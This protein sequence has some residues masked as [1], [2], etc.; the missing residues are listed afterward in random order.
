MMATPMSRLLEDVSR[1]HFPLSARHARGD[2]SVRAA[3]G[4]DPDLRVFY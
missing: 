4:L 3:G 1:D 2:R